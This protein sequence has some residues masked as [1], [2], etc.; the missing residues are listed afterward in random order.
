MYSQILAEPKK[1]SKIQKENDLSK[2]IFSQN[3]FYNPISYT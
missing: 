3:F 2:T 1:P